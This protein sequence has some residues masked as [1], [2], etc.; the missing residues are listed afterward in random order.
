MSWFAPHDAQGLINLMGGEESFV[1]HLNRNFEEGYYTL[2]NECP[3]NFPW[4]FSYAGRPDLTMKWVNHTLRKFFKNKPYGV[5]GNDD[6]GT[7]SSVYMWGALGLFP[8]A[9]GSG[10]L[11]INGPLFDKVT[12]HRS[13]TEKITLEAKNV[14]QNNIYIQSARLGGESLDQVFVKINDLMNFS[15]VFEMGESPN[16]S[17]GSS[18]KKPYSV[19]TEEPAF[20]LVDFTMDK[21]KVSPNDPVRVSCVVRNKGAVG[22]YLLEVKDGDKILHSEYFMIEGGKEK[23]LEANIRLYQAGEHSISVENMKELVEVSP[24]ELRLV[25]ALHIEQVVIDPLIDVSE[26]AKWQVSVK[27]ISGET[28]SFEPSLFLNDKGVENKTVL[29]LEPGQEQRIEGSFSVDGF[30][31]FQSI[32]LNHGPNTKFKVYEDQEETLVV[33]YDFETEGKDVADRSG[34]ENHGIVRGELDWVV[35]KK[36]Q[37]IQLID[38]HISIPRSASTEIAGD[39]LTML[40]W[41]KPIDQKGTAPLITKGGFHML[42]LN[43]KRQLKFAAGSW[44]RGQCF[45]NSKPK[46]DNMRQPKWMEEWTHFA[47]V[48]DASHIRVIVDGRERNRLDHNGPIKN[49][50]FEWQVGGN[51]EHPQGRVA[52]GILD[53]VRIYAGSLSE[54]EIRDIMEGVK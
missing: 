50:E 18:G 45:F 24:T 39:N 14:S 32:R 36:G 43:G 40:A 28:R 22:N 37:G 17:F 41:Y 1:D 20:E 31:G 19:T 23:E 30:K 4:L 5:P 21:S 44:G 6:W 26:E 49:S 11:I 8:A 54:E 7:M 38:G 3:M 25:E 9:P 34:F 13:E 51:Q 12:I 52:Q 46:E 53:E 35:G 29:K 2:D 42:K 47:G 15:L 16:D 10:E 27:N 33:H 48:K